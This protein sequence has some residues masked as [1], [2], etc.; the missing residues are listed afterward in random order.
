MEPVLSSYRLSQSLIQAIP[1]GGSPLLQLPHFTPKIVAA[2]EGVRAP[3]HTSIQKFNALPTSARKSKTVGP[4]LLTDRE[5]QQSMA[6]AASLPYLQVEHTFFK[7]HGERYVTPG[8][9]VQ[10]IVKA[11]FIPPGSV[12]V[13]PPTEA[14]LQEL[15][16]EDEG[17]RAKAGDENPPPLAHAPLFARGHAPKW[18]VFLS[19]AKQGKIVVPPFTFSTFEKPL[20][21]SKGDPTYAVQTLKAQFGA[22]PQEGNYSFTMNLICDSTWDSTRSGM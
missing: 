3:K 15:D 1:P 17:K 16:K 21:D 4:G 12:N 10:F 7:V 13:P 14:D 22:P 8:S 9:L 5:F 18:H 19:D 20:F 2:I 11:R 6:V